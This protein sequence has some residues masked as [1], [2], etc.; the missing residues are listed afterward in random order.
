MD[1]YINRGVNL[2]SFSFSF[3]FSTKVLYIL[4]YEIENK[5]FGG[6]MFVKS[7]MV[8]TIALLTINLINELEKRPNYK[9]TILRRE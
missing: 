5:V 2:L 6:F 3:R 8:I 4:L 7:L 9:I 1:D